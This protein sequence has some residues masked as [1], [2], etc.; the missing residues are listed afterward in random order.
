M[1]EWELVQ[2]LRKEAEEARQ[3]AL[4]A[5]AEA[6]RTREALAQRLA[7]L[8]REAER[9][10]QIAEA[11]ARLQPGDRVVVPR[12]GYDRPG[13]IVK[14]DPRKKTAVIA[15]GHVHLGRRDRRADP[16][17]RRAPRKSRPSALDAAKDRVP[18]RSSP[19]TTSSES[20]R[21]RDPTLSDRART[22]G[23]PAVDS[24]TRH[25]PAGVF[26]KRTPSGGS[27]SDR[28]NGR[29]AWGSG[30]AQTPPWLPTFE[31]P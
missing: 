1:P 8:Q 14:L 20:D 17:G 29:P 10:D 26:R 9:E 19:W 31:P 21:G 5:Q 11:R 6:E 12:L 4:Q 23:R 15:I 22:R 25:E 30:T 2:K 24:V 3:S 7:D 13:R 27:R 16:P 18:G 28:W